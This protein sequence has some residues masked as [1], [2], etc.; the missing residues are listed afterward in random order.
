METIT[1]TR[2]NGT[3]AHRTLTLCPCRRTDIDALL[4]LQAEI[5]AG[6]VDP[7]L[8]FPTSRQ[9]FNRYFTQKEQLW[10]LWDHDALAACAI[11]LYPG[12]DEENY[13][14]FLGVPAAELPLW[15]NLDT[16]FVSAAYRGNGLQQTLISLCEKQRRPETV[17]FGCTVAPN[18]LPSLNNFLT[19]GYSVHSQLPMY[20]G[21][22]R[23][24]LYKRF[25]VNTA[26]PFGR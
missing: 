21:L 20:G 24:L 11:L 17:G 4:S 3:P 16:I 5:C 2:Y 25:P 19:M 8:F 22:D 14:H 18:N 13:G 15:G 10:C 9:D 6:L 1:I 26:P 12:T 23:F 7:A